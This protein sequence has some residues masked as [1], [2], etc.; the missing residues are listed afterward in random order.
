M[1]ILISVIIVNYNTKELTK[2]CIE[3]IFDKTSNIDFEIILVDNTSTDG[4]KELFSRDKRIKYIYNDTNYGFGKANNIGASHAKGEYLFLLN[5]DTILLNN[6]LLSFYSFFEENKENAKIGVVGGILLSKEKQ[7]IH[8]FGFFPSMRETLKN[9][10]IGYL[11]KNHYI[12]LE[13]KKEQALREVNRTTQV[14]YVT[15][16]NMFLQKRVY[17]SFGG[18]DESFFM[19]YEETNLQKNICN[20]G[21]SNYIITEPQII[22]LEGASMKSNASRVSMQKRILMTKS[23]FNYFRIQSSF[24]TY[25]I[26]RF[27]YAFFRL[28]SLTNRNYSSKEKIHY[29]KTLFS[30]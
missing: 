25:F 3:S 19:Y 2:D 22:H 11:D 15:G 7:R 24:F 13:R 4:S 8:S 1:S 9:I 5:S 10:L 12:K 20:E 6:S 21:Y 23:M 30:I 14:D 18:F 27:L 29:L 26:F 17:N 16:A 28:P